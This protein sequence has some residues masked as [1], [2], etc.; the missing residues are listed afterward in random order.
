MGTNMNKFVGLPPA[1]IK[2]LEAAQHLFV[3]DQHNDAYLKEKLPDH[4]HL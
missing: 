4:R 3:N 2:Y 1:Q